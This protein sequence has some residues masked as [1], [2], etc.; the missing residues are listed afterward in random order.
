MNLAK[1]GLIVFCAVLT[2]AMPTN[3]FAV[4]LTEEQIGNISS[5]C[6]SIK[7]QLQKVQR[8]DAKSRVHLG[9]QFEA[10]A[11]S[12]MMNLNLRLVK[13]NRAN[14]DIASQQAEF[15]NVRERFKKDYIEYQKE[16]EELISINCK[17]D[18][19]RFYEQLEYVRA[20]R[21]DMGW[22]ITRLREIADE[23]RRSVLD[24]REELYDKEHSNE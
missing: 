3:L 13:N 4:E 21:D 17:D 2:A 14:G 12:L 19:Y 7:L 20:R 15:S 5:N 23:H 24:M 16:L 22:S 6:S 18:P 8:M 11:N 9:A 10:I 1:K